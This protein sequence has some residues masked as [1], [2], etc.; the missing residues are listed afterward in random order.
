M[1]TKE[2]VLDAVGDR[3]RDR[4]TGTQ[5]QI[6]EPA[7]DD[8]MREMVRREAIRKSV[9]TESTFSF[10]AA[11]RVYTFTDSPATGMG[12]ARV[13]ERV[14]ALYVPAWG[15]DEEVVFIDHRSPRNFEVEVEE[16]GGAATTGRPYIWRFTASGTGIEIHKVPTS[17][18]A[19]AATIEYD[20]APAALATSATITFLTDAELPVLQDGILYRIAPLFESV[21]DQTTIFQG[22]YERG[23]GDMIWARY[24]E[25]H[26][27]DILA[28]NEMVQ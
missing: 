8:V 5:N 10:V 7:F 9:R 19:S 11:Q 18:Y 27:N 16:T 24:R 3:V 6:L 17:T 1:A 22:N 15:A 25:D 12:L 2:N 21:R 4:S 13:P 23:L 28:P 26:T 20:I 14:H